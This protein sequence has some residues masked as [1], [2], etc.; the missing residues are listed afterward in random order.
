MSGI[1][2]RK[3]DITQSLISGTWNKENVILLQSVLNY[4]ICMFL[5]QRNYFTLHHAIVDLY[6]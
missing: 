2:V 4:K 5:F 3:R 6:L 1:I